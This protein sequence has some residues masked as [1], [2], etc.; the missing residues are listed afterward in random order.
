M[1]P[2]HTSLARTLIAN[3]FPFL[4]IQDPLDTYGLIGIALAQYLRAILYFP[5]YKE[6][7]GWLTLAR[8]SPTLRGVELLM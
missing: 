2:T 8:R 6:G 7:R 4:L 1:F 3:A 5:W